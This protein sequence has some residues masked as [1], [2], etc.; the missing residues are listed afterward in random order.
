MRAEKG[1]PEWS[2]LLAN[3]RR[4]ALVLGHDL[5]GNYLHC[6][7]AALNQ[8]LH[9]KRVWLFA[10][11][12]EPPVSLIYAFTV[13]I[14]SYGSYARC[15]IPQMTSKSGDIGRQVDQSPDERLL[16]PH[17]DEL[18]NGDDV[19]DVGSF[20]RTRPDNAEYDGGTDTPE[21]QE[22]ETVRSSQN[23]P[24]IAIEDEAANTGEISTPPEPDLSI[25]VRCEATYCR[26]WT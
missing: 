22:L 6:L 16:S 26:A 3:E 10:Q 24:V 7:D 8:I 13:C 14:T 20:S 17:R 4:G 12:L 18:S 11:T 25:Q 15:A 19:S 21:L 1:T 2:C 9:A 23:A 5:H